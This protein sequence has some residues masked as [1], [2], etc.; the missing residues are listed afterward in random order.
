MDLSKTFDTIH[1]KLLIEKLAAYE[2]DENAL[3]TVHSYIL[4][5][6][7]RTK[8]NPSF[9]LWRELL[10]GVTQGSVLGPILSNIYLNDLFFQLLDTHVC[11]FADDT[12]LN[13]CDIVLR[14]ILL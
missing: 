14:N 2:F 7:L 4:E 9:S 12:T 5:R 3:Q 6:W 10:C 11:N 13:A 1:H 8:V